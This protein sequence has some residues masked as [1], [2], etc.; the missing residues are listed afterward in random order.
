M[1]DFLNYPFMQRAFAGA[2]I[3]SFLAGYYGVFVVQRKMSFLGSG[4][5]H[6]SFGGIALGLLLSIEPIAVALPFAVMVAAGITW[7]NKESQLSED[8]IIGIFF[9]VSMALG[10]IFLYLKSD[11]SADAMTFLFGSILAIEPIDIYTA[12]AVT[13]LTI[14][15]F[16]VWKRWAYAT[17]DRELALTDKIPVHK[18]DYLLATLIA[19]TIVVSIKLVGIIMISAFLVIPPATARLIA[20]SFSRMTILSVALGIISSF[21][22]L[23]VSYL[24]NVPAGAT[25]I[26]LEAVIFIM[27]FLVSG[28][29]V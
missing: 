9:V 5:A 19:I 20:K 6:A 21:V 15:S 26:L 24:L 18:D 13:V 25:I 2:L 7:L 10:I 1:F 12:L 16:P 28:K 3:I 14:F 17:F 11:Y 8:T 22:G 4:L 23:V 27:A 29:S